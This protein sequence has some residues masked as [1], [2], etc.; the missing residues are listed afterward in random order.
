MTYSPDTGRPT[1][2]SPLPAA[3][4]AGEPGERMVRANGVRLCTQTFGDA[5]DPAILLIMGAAAS[6]DWWEDGFCERLAAGRRFVIRYDHRDTGRSVCYQRGAPPYTL[7]DLAADAVGLLDAF[8]LARAHLVGFSMGGAI[9]QLVALDHPGRV[10]SLTLIATSPA[11]PGDPGLPGM[12]EPTQAGFATIAEP[13]WSDRAAVIGYL[14]DLARVSASRSRPIDE[15]AVRALAGRV[16]DRTAS[17]ASSMT[18]HDA[19]SGDGR[20][21][22]RLGELTAPALVVHGTHDPVL[23]FGHGL[24][25]AQEIPGAHLL[26]LEQTGHELPRSVWDV[27]V[28]AILWHTSDN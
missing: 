25:L 20:W 18:N 26:P 28:P 6:M 2:R 4:P 1:L 13:A 5:G 7:R 11:G 10:E 15:E 17:I 3:V 24:A 19:M 14:V 27:V 21:R 22:E 9:A 12:P 23:P 8:S 16:I